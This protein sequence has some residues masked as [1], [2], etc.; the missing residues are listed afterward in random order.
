MVEG[1]EWI[2]R[3]GDRRP[4]AVV[5]STQRWRDDIEDL[6]DGR[7]KDGTVREGRPAMWSATRRPWRLATLANA[8]SDVACEIASGSLRHHL[9]IDV[10]VVGLICVVHCDTAARP[11]V[12]PGQFGQWM[13]GLTPIAP[14]TTSAPRTR[15]SAKVT[16]RSSTRPRT[17]PFR[18]PHRGSPVRRAPAPRVQVE[19]R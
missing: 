16:D 8:M 2:A 15:P 9:R 3:K 7:T 13:S 18:P 4:A 1:C 19:R 14:T 17:L 6:D 11:D 10:R 12:E 5:R